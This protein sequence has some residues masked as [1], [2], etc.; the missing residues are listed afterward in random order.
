M[1]CLVVAVGSFIL[2]SVL[3]TFFNTETVNDFVE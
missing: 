2:R 3:N 1:G